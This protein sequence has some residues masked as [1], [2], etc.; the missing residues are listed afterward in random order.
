MG[1]A[2]GR[3]EGETLVVE[4]TNFRDDSAF[5]GA[6]GATLKITE[7]FTRI[8]KEQV[9]WQVT[10]DD[11]MTWTRPWTFAMPLTIDNTQPV[12]EYACHEG[13]LGLRNILSSARAE[14]KKAAEAAAAKGRD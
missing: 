10:V 4:T 1:D 5:R 3:W 7:R 8:S 14:E 13:N 6:N 11:P 2:R 12:L 9:R